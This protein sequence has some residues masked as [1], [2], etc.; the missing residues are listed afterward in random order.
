MKAPSLWGIFFWWVAG[1]RARNYM[2]SWFD[3]LMSSGICL[4]LVQLLVGHS[5]LNS[6]S[7]QTLNLSPSVPPSFVGF[8]YIYIKAGFI[9]GLRGRCRQGSFPFR[10]LFSGW[11]H[12]WMAEHLTLGIHL[13][14]GF[15]P[16]FARSV[17]ALCWP[18]PARP[19]ECQVSGLVQ[20][21]ALLHL[22]S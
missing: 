14:P 8:F 11:S 15:V 5:V 16:L 6:E 22:Q 3:F 12:T 10:S 4:L 20:L 1:E 18:V 13:V 2:S 21:N 9:P 17:E 19:G 7:V